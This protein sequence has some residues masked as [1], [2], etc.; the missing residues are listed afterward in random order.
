MAK[1]LIVEDD[2]Y[3][4]DAINGVLKKY[5]Y[6]VINAPNGRVAKNIIKGSSPDLILSDIQMPHFTGIELLDWCKSENITHK[7]ILMTG[8][9]HLMKPEEAC[10]LGA[11]EFLLKP[12]V[13]TELME[14]L[15][16]CL[17]ID[18]GNDNL[19]ITEPMVD[20]NY[21][22]VSIDDFVTG[23]EVPFNVFVKINGSKYLRIA[24]KGEDIS[25]EKIKAYK[26]KGL[27]YLYL[28]KEDFHEL[29]GFNIKLAGAVKTSNKIKKSVKQNFL[30]Y[31]GEIILENCF[32][33]N[34]DEKAFTDSQKFVEL[35]LSIFADDDEAFR[36]L[37]V[38]NSH[39][40]FLYA[41]SLGVSIYSVMIAKKM[42]WLSSQNLFKISTAGLFHDIGKKEIDRSILEKPRIDLTPAERRLVE[43]H[44]QRG[45]EILE[46]IK[47]IPGEVAAAAFE[48]HEKYLGQGYPRGIFKNR[49]S[50]IARV[51][52]IADVFCN[53]AIKNPT[54]DGMSGGAAYVK[55]NEAHENEF[56]PEIIK[57]F[58]NLIYF[59]DNKKKGN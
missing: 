41:H 50:P 47:C 29:V 21:C 52:A 51:I 10:K 26:Q 33:V 54:S 36:I 44:P 46:S 4:S 55:M 24:Y 58:G 59:D 56:D 19:D 35:S 11:D 40:D 22:K 45:K 3:F 8:F 30:R 39:A 53:Y 23:R 15:T 17:P 7:F 20:Q 9:S 16:S 42:G 38:L 6:N 18:C 28:K 31:T 27:F 5:N 37:S 34:I 32:V 2:S 12:F 48:H 1:I 13:E 49:I 14:K 43:T 57:T 25:I